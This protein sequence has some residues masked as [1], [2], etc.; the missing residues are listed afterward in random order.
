MTQRAIQNWLW[1][2]LKLKGHE[3]M[4]PN[5]TPKNWFECDMFSVTKKGYFVE[6]E[7]KL[8]VA[9][10]KADAKKQWD[11]WNGKHGHEYER[12]TH[13]KHDLLLG[14]HPQGPTRFFYVV[15]SG[16]IQRDDVP[17][18][19]G[20]LYA[21]D[22]NLAERPVNKISFHEVLEAPVLHREKFDPQML[23]RL[24]VTFYWRFWTER[25]KEKI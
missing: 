11:K 8:S 19:A 21:D 16:L 2:H 25:R 1:W 13:K 23:T 10:F 15:P 24:G 22:L 4:C 17:S 14:N 9:D 7:I 3:W 20:L 6:H 5:Y 12:L 18:W